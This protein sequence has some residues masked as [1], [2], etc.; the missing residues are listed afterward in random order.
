MSSDFDLGVN[1]CWLRN[2]R[3]VCKR[4]AVLS[5]SIDVQKK[6]KGLIFVALG[7]ETDFSPCAHLGR[8][9]IISHDLNH[10]PGHFHLQGWAG[11]GNRSSGSTMTLL[12]KQSSNSFI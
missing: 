4:E 8:C 5:L 3:S 11:L 12:V 10:S 2:G 9:T 7:H 1:A 6:N